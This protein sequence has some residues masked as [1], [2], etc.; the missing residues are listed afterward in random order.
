MIRNLSKINNNWIY[1]I[2]SI[3]VFLTQ[4]S[5][6]EFEVIDWD[7]STYLLISKYLS[8]GVK[9]KEIPIINRVDD[10]NQ[11]TVRYFYD[12]FDAF[13]DLLRLRKLEGRLK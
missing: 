2:I 7:E 10:T 6:I 9:I 11:T 5:Y 1:L 12:S 8:E 3:S 4:F 13:I